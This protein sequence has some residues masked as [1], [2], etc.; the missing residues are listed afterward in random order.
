M[1]R[2]M[3]GCGVT[4]GSRSDERISCFRRLFIFD[5]IFDF[6]FFKIFLKKTKNR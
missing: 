4:N 6:V 5:L 3:S 2:R 1:S